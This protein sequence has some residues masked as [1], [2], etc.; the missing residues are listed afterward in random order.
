MVTLQAA[1]EGAALE[2]RER[3]DD[4]ARVEGMGTHKCDEIARV[5]AEERLVTRRASAEIHLDAPVADVLDGR[6]DGDLVGGFETPFGCIF[7]DM[8]LDEWYGVEISSQFGVKDGLKLRE[9][10]ES[11]VWRI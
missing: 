8:A 10:T 9:S 5:I 1:R 2:A 11:T 6:R 3:V 4:T 7:A